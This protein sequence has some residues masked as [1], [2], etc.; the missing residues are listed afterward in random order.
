MHFR[1]LSA[2]ITA[3]FLLAACEENSVS[4][5]GQAGD[6]GQA[7]V[8]DG[9][10]TGDD[11]STGDNTSDDSSTG[12]DSSP[13]DDS[14]IDDDT[15]DDS[16]TGDDSSSGDDPATG[17]DTSADDEPTPDQN[18]EFILPQPAFS[19]LRYTGPADDHL[20]VHFAEYSALGGDVRSVDDLW[21]E[22]YLSRLDERPRWCDDH[23][24]RESWEEIAE[25]IARLDEDE[26]GDGDVFE[27][28]SEQRFSSDGVDYGELAVGTRIYRLPSTRESAQL[29]R[30]VTVSA[31]WTGY[32]AYLSVVSALPDGRASIPFGEVSVGTFVRIY[33]R[34]EGWERDEDDRDDDDWDD[35]DWDDWDNDKH[36]S[37]DFVLL[38]EATLDGDER[39]DFRLPANSP[40]WRMDGP[41][42]FSIEI[43]QWVTVTRRP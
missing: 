25:E 19:S 38:A 31:D 29:S 7:V 36:D 3:L 2:A 26:Y 21:R 43:S 18:G 40:Y 6:D 37:G 33:G 16:P 35:D 20:H 41:V 11:S 27:A 39:Y 12:G 5:D 23:R 14:S 30:L 8:G 32:P 42:R 22:C 13:G 1:L 24:L 28:R 34:D 9:P 10:A 4:S 17:D 15:S